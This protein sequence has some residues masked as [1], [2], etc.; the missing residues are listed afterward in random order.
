LFIPQDLFNICSNNLPAIDRE[1]L[2]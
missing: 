1:D 2:D